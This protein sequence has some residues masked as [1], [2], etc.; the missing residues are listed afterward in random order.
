MFNW[1][2]DRR[3][4]RKITLAG[5]DAA[6]EK[7]QL[8][9]IKDGKRL[10][11]GT[12]MLEF[13]ED[14]AANSRHV[15]VRKA[16]LI[17]LLW[18]NTERGFRT[19]LRELIRGSESTPPWEYW[20]NDTGVI[21]HL[22]HLEAEAVPALELRAKALFAQM[23]RM[24]YPPL[25]SEAEGLHKTLLLILTPRARAAEQRFMSS[26]SW[27][28]ENSKP[29][30]LTNPPGINPP[31][32]PPPLEPGAVLP[33][34]YKVATGNTDP[35]AL[36]RPSE[37]R[38][39]PMDPGA[40]YFW[41]DSSAITASGNSFYGAYVYGRLLPCFA[42]GK[43]PASVSLTFVD[44]DYLPTGAF[45]VPTQGAEEARVLEKAMKLESLAYIVGIYAHV[46]VSF[47]AIDDALRSGG[48]TGYLGMTSTPAVSIADFLALR[49]AL[50]LP[51]SFKL[52]GNKIRKADFA[53]LGDARLREMGFEV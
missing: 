23:E 18:S 20:L 48:V 43:Q 51:V 29:V 46:G 2:H 21:S 28:K 6:S 47:T 24:G 44:G 40:A 4:L 36:S 50:S 16:A 31:V 49:E 45:K 37:E 7:G 15:S 34:P 12:G 30:A 11:P 32:A 25:A 42:P 8:Q 5:S 10:L 17:S 35:Q 39:F 52:E 22:R 41:F 13:L 3:H 9:A 26:L 53:F 38:R 27:H 19:V 1:L 14:R 33:T